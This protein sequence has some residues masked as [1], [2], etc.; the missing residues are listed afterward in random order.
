MTK[1][2]VHGNPEVDA[3]WGPL[4][5]ELRARGVADIVLLSPPGFGA[6]VPDGWDASMRS[7][8][9]WLVGE[10][11]AI[12][13]ENG[14]EIDLVGHDWGAGHV[15]GLLDVRP[16]LIRSYAA[17]VAGLL[18][19]DYVWHDAAQAWQ[20]PDVG[21]QFIDGMVSASLDDRTALFTGM[22]VAPEIARTLAEGVDEEMGRC[23]LALYRD[24][25]QP[26]VSDLGARLFAADPPPG[27]VINATADSYVSPDLGSEVT[28]LLGAGE[29]RLE[30]LG[31]WWMTED[32]ARAADGL[33]EFW[34]GL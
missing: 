10:L 11:E 34:S 14:G 15:Y 24:A 31:H 27:L 23:I 21:E 12:G 16:D 26:A 2:F 6:P 17:D 29:L 28:T 25:V 8:V 13:G 1:V 9:E 20:T 33:V 4:V 30:G 32:P 7:Y 19:E 22:G 5:D 3:L 18:H